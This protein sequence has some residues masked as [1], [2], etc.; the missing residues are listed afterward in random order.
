MAAI[1]APEDA[2]IRKCLKDAYHPNEEDPNQM[3]GIVQEA[4]EEFFYGHEKRLKGPFESW[5]SLRED[6]AHIREE[7]PWIFAEALW[8]WEELFHPNDF[9]VTLTISVRLGA[10]V[11]LPPLPDCH[12]TASRD[13][14]GMAGRVI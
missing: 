3:T 11:P 14:P 6:E 13:R 8:L 10:E 5:K 12:S 4:K 1:L 2:L 7:T 9:L